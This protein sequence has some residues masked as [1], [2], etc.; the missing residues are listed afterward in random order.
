MFVLLDRDL[1]ARFGIVSVEIYRDNYFFVYPTIVF[2][3]CVAFVRTRYLF[4]C[5]WQSI[6]LEVV[7]HL[8]SY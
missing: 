2:W 4:M 5:L 1:F 8:L 3:L 6:D 7:T